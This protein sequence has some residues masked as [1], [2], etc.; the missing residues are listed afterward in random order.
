MSLGGNIKKFRKK[1]KLKQKE[2]A[3]LVGK[4][5]ST[6]QKYE[7]NE[8]NPNIET[9]NDIAKIFNISVSELV[10]TKNNNTMQTV[11]YNYYKTLSDEKLL[12]ILKGTSL[13]INEENFKKLSK[14]IK[15]N[16]LKDLS[17]VSVIKLL[18]N[19]QLKSF[20]NMTKNDLI[21]F[22]TDIEEY[23]ISTIN[24]F[25]DSEYENLYNKYKLATET[26]ENYKNLCEVQK[27]YIEKSKS[28]LNNVFN[29]FDKYKD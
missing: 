7:A 16:F 25:I 18:L 5:L 19:R 29:T 23:F 3:Q 13:K 2:F 1:N 17:N 12:E 20:D 28:M 27:E 24:N 22:C 4:S 6:I 9:L 26:L 14:E 10:D 21:D 11:N 8:V 15:E